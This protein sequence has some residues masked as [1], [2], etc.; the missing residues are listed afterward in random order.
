[1]RK[2]ILPSDC[3]VSSFDFFSE[4]R[5]EKPSNRPVV[6]LPS[7]YLTNF[8]H[9]EH[10]DPGIQLLIHHGPLKINEVEVKILIK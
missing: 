9:Q 1:M 7:Q 3:S 4:G 8:S 5:N 2:S 10:G 6:V